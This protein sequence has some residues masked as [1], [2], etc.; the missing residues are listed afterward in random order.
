[1]NHDNRKNSNCKRKKIQ[2]INL[3]EEELAKDSKGLA[4]RGAGERNDNL[5]IPPF[6]DQVPATAAC[7]AQNPD[8]ETRRVLP[9]CSGART[10]AFKCNCHFVPLGE[11][12]TPLKKIE[13]WLRLIEHNDV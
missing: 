8:V 3:T 2:A 9:R 7:V 12:C 13:F 1:L 6:D 11:V 10:Y 4:K 5:K